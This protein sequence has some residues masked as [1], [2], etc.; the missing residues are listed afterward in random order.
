MASSVPGIAIAPA[1]AQFAALVYGTGF[2]HVDTAA[3]Y[4]SAIE[5]SDRIV[6]FRIILHL[7]EPKPAHPSRGSLGGKRYAGN[8]A[9]LLEDRPELAFGHVEVEVSNIELLHSRPLYRFGL[10]R[11]ETSLIEQCELKT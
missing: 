7:D 2:V 3:A 8:G 6:G 5:R 11:A 4:V 1:A 10:W 9:E